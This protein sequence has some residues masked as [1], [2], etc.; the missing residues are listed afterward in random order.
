MHL[1]KAT[2]SSIGT[3]YANHIYIH[4]TRIIQETQ[5]GADNNE[6]GMLCYVE[7]KL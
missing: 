7:K 6:I 3:Q 5:S 4:V 2:G 1:A